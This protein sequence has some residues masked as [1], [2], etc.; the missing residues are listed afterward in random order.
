M[1]ALGWP[2]ADHFR[3]KRVEK[4][5]H[6]T[7]PTSLATKVLTWLYQL[8]LNLHNPILSGQLT[9]EKERT[10]DPRSFLSTLTYTLRRK[11]LLINTSQ[12]IKFF[13]CK[14][15]NITTH[16]KHYW[17]KLHNQKIAYLSSTTWTNRSRLAMDFSAAVLIDFTFFWKFSFTWITLNSTLWKTTLLY[18]YILF[19]RNVIKKDFTGAEINNKQIKKMFNILDISFYFPSHFHP[20]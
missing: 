9:I 1:A 19:A 10:M 5:A 3:S 2:T 15:L 14:F 17:T 8:R 4:L 11:I 20:L 16:K 13:V 18:F 7:T 12:N 6:T